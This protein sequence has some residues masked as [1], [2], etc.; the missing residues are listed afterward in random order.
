MEVTLQDIA[1]EVN[2]SAQ[3]V[4]RSLRHDSGIS[5]ETRA[6]VSEVARRLGYNSRASR[7]G[8]PRRPVERD[9]KINTLGLLL[10]HSSLDAAQHDGNLMKMMAGIMSVT[11]EHGMRLKVHTRQRQDFPIEDDASLLPSLLD[12]GVCKAL[13][14]HGEQDE[15]ELDFLSH[16]MPV[17]SMGRIYEN[18]PIDA[19]VADNARGVD[20]LVAHL[21][22]LGHRRLAWVG[23][24]YSTATFIQERQAGF[25]Q[26]CQKQG[27]GLDQLV[28]FGPEI[29]KEEGID[30]DTLLAAAK[31]GVTGFVCGNDTIALEVITA[32]EATGLQVPDDA[33]VTGFDGWLAQMKMRGVTSVDPNFLEIGKSAARLALQRMAHLADGPR[34]VS[35]RGKI[36]LGDTTAPPKKSTSGE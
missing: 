18:L 7:P 11:D 6:R 12:G 21:V 26:G 8:R 29:Y 9:N 27:L 10:R 14:A 34:V 17:V 35:V 4:S 19:A 23:A 32:L 16:R 36:V 24:L 15:S 20:N 22:S 33:S 13:I 30:K 2:V 28:F 31:G 5:P 25:F 3:T 1:K